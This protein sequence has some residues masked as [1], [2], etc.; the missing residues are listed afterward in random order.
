MIIACFP[1]ALVFARL[2]DSLKAR[3][4]LITMDGHASKGNSHK[5]ASSITGVLVELVELGS[6]GNALLFTLLNVGKLLCD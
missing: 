4:K 5:T 1:F 2:V 3:A 6:V